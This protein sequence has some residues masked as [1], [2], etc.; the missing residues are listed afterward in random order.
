MSST[1]MMCKLSPRHDL[2]RRPVLFL[3]SAAANMRCSPDPVLFTALSGSWLGAAPLLALGA[4]SDMP[5][6]PVPANPAAGASTFA[7]QATLADKGVKK[8]CRKPWLSK[9]TVATC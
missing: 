7:S 1:L 2:R 8:R 9:A 3:N 4:V 5:C 6:C